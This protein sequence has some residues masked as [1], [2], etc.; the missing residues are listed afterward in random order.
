MSVNKPLEYVMHCGIQGAYVPVHWKYFVIE[1]HTL[2]LRPDQSISNI[3]VHMDYFNDVLAM[4]LGLDRVAVYEGSESS[5]S[6]LTIS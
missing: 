1:T 4:F 2:C 6:S 5:R 3:S